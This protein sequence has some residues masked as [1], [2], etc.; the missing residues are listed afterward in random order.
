MK[1]YSVRIAWNHKG[2][3]YDCFDT[4]RLKASSVAAA[5]S[6]AVAVIKKRHKDSY[7]EPANSQVSIHVLVIGDEKTQEA[8]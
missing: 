2:S 1:T 8:P 4:F 6:K 3:R 7:R 5:A